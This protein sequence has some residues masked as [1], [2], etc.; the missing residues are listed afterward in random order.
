MASTTTTVA[1]YLFAR[2]HQLGV[3]SVYGVPGDYNL[4]LLD[5]LEPAGLHWAGNCNELNAG[6]AADGY[7]RVKGIGAL[8]TTFGVGELSAINAIAG[9][10]AE[11]ASV[12][13]IVGTPSRASQDS[14]AL[15][16]HTLNDGDYRRFAQMHAHVTTA[17]VNLT[18]PRTCSA[19]IDFALEQCLLQSRPVYIEV[20]ADMVP[21][22]IAS[23]RL[24]T[25]ISIDHFAQPLNATAALALVLD[26]MYS[27]KSPMILVDGEIRAFGAIDELNQLV[28]LTDWPTWTT[29]FGKGLIDENLQNNLGIYKGKI[30]QQHVKEY[31][32]SCD[33]ILSFGPHHSDSNTYQ[34]SNIPNPAVT[35]SFGAT[36]IQSDATII[37]DLPMKPFLNQLLTNLEISKLVS[38]SPP[39]SVEGNVVDSVDSPGDSETVTHCHFWKTMS[40]F[41]RPGD[42]VLG[43]TGTSAHGS[44]ELVLPQTARYFTAVTWL[45]IGYMLP[46]AL[47]ASMAQRELHE[48]NSHQPDQSRTLLFVGDGSLQVSVQAL[49]DVIRQKVDMIVFVINNDGYTIERCIHG[50]NRSYNDVAPWRYLLAPAFFGVDEEGEY[51]AHTYSVATWAELKN[52]LENDELKRGKGLHMVEVFMSKEDAPP[53]LLALLEKQKEAEK[54]RDSKVVE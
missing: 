22:P 40:S 38:V 34:Y 23:A 37:R 43:E 19:Q 54:E 3:R 51:R 44:R 29:T 42:I 16:H 2:L 15:I 25:D 5:Y 31:V 33:L 50:R 39:H 48:E 49:S 41:L 17:Q 7:S 26:R 8:I 14:H 18:D 47:G 6:Y 36:E 4:T 45:S 28:R 13:H 32:Q 11:K 1:G 30:S 24:D 20:P 10:Y 53:T 52:V 9:A 46:A 35:I 27:C 12:V 21:I